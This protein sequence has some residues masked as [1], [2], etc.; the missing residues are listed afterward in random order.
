MMH[1]GGSM[2]FYKYLRLFESVPTTSYH[3]VETLLI[4]SVKYLASQFNI[5]NQTDHSKISLNQDRWPLLIL[6]TLNN[7]P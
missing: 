5:D 7:N 1:G 3:L 2:R 6:Y 4:E